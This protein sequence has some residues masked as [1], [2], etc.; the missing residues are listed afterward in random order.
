[1]LRGVSPGK[2]APHEVTEVLLPLRGGAR[3]AGASAGGQERGIWARIKPWLCPFCCV[4]LASRFTSL[5][6]SFLCV[7]GLPGQVM[8]T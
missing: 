8:E 3:G 5:G 6:L 1:M 2:Q 4:T 7:Q